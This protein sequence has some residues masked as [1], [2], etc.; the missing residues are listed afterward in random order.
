MNM[1]VEELQNLAADWRS[2]L[3]VGV[4][5]VLALFSAVQS[6]R[7]PWL[8]GKINP[9]DEEIADAKI[10]QRFISPRFAVVMLAGFGLTLAGLMMITHGVKP[11][12]ALAAMVVGLVIIQTEPARL[13]IREA[14][15]IVLAATDRSE[16][17]KAGARGRLR[18]S[19]RELATVN[20]GILICLIG[21]MLAF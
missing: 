17:T 10:I 20:I 21:G 8:T 4:M 6:V 9:T 7:C 2:W 19:Y 5:A 18:S 13:R 1:L 15:R 16:D 11:T 3:V 14:R 12:L